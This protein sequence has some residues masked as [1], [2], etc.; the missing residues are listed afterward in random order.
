MAP[1]SFSAQQ[2]ADQLGCHVETIRR[3]VR[4]KE[5]LATKDPLGR[6]RGYVILA[7]DLA[8]FVEKRKFG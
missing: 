8:S 6:G 2:A 4:R 3:A 5:L 7:T 1:R